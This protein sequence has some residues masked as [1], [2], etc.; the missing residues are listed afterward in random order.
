MYDRDRQPQFSGQSSERDE[1]IA[2]ALGINTSGQQSEEQRLLDYLL[3][4]GFTQNEAIKL[5]Y[6]RVHLYENSEMRQRVHDDR[7]IQ[8]ARW[9]YE[10]GEISA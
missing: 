6:Q 7:R 3:G 1:A 4:T 10:H 8:F 2:H 9:L 5:V